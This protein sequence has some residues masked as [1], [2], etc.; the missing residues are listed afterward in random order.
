MNRPLGGRIIEQILIAFEAC[1]R[2]AVDDRV[3]SLQV[4]EGGPSHVK[5]AVDVDAKRAIPILVADLIE[6]F[7]MFL[8]C[9]VVDEDVQLPKRLDGLLHGTFT[10]PGIADV[11]MNQQ[12]AASEF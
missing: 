12:C 11:A 7:L 10:E 5:V 2:T 4:F 3:T 6:R 9:R 1:D 8:K